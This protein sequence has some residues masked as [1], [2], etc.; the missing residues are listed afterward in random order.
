MSARITAFL[1]SCLGVSIAC[2]LGAGC[3]SKE[4]I[5]PLKDG[6]ELVRKTPPNILMEPSHDINELRYRD[7]N[8]KPTVVWN[9]L[10]SEVFQKDGISVF[11]AQKYYLWDG[12]DKRWGQESRVFAVKSTELPADISTEIVG[13]W[14]KESGRDIGTTLTNLYSSGIMNIKAEDGNLSFHFDESDFSTNDASDI[15]VSWDQIKS[16]AGFVK[17]N[18][19]V[20]KDPELGTECYEIKFEPQAE[21]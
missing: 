7:T 3:G 6:F 17:T 16:M 12:L 8:G 15:H 1:I 18:G 11:L 9:Y 20:H 14:A 21:K 5:T 2:Y 4:Q 10:E 19:V 13:K